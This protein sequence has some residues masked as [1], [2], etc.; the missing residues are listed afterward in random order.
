MKTMWR[1]LI[2]NLR[3]DCTFFAPANERAIERSEE[4][5][6]IALP[7]ELKNFLLESDGLISPEG[8]KI[9]WCIEEIQWENENVRGMSQ[10]HQLY[11]PFDNLVFFSGNLFCNFKPTLPQFGF[12]YGILK[13]GD[14][15]NGIFAWSDDDSRMRIASDLKGYLESSLIGELQPWWLE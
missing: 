2:D 15:Y 8:N 5:L 9:I 7:D 6:Q 12:A 11:M 4:A 10:W 3:P 14:S 13:I 1:T